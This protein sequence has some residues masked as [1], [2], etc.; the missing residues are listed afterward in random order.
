MP[1]SRPL[2]PLLES[3][4]RRLLRR[5][6]LRWHCPR[7]AAVGVVA[8][9]NL[10][11]TLGRFVTTEGRIELAARTLRADAFREVLTHEAAHAC[12]TLPSAAAGSTPPMAATRR[13]PRPHGP[14]WRS[15]MSIAGFPNAAATR[16][17]RPAKARARTETTKAKARS[18]ESV[19]QSRYVH[20][21]PVCQASRT[22]RR[23]VTA[24]RCAACVAAGLPGQLQITRRKPRR[25]E[26]A[27]HP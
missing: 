27:S 22:A 1:A 12:L 10:R 3:Q 26:A 13:S 19:D 18:R 24:W 17:C 15:L 21:C 4:A 25:P 23:P 14:A 7:L 11:R 9:P 16:W 8:R 20:W 6:A 2:P 5:L